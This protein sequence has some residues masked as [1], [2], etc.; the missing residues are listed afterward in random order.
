MFNKKDFI[1]HKRAAYSQEGCN[2]AINFFE[3][4]IDLHQD[5]AVRGK[6]GKVVNYDKK[7]CTELYLN[8]HDYT[9]FEDVVQACIKD[10][11]KRYPMA[12]QILPYDI[13]RLIK[14]QRYKP[15]EGYFIEHCE[16]YGMEGDVDTVLAWMIYLNDVTDGGH[17]VFPSQNRK[18]QPRRG[19][20]LMWPAYF[21]HSHHG[22]VSKTQ[23]K[24]IVTGWCT[25]S[26]DKQ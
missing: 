6:D 11:G 12:S 5:G 22:I 1:Y 24:Y 14:I 21:T 15:G 10:Y 9:L 7:K 17:T 18:F 16:N 26:P 23:T 8:R 13:R 25:F 20:L 3:K 4:R 2:H 19:D